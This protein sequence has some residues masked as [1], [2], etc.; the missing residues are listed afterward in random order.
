M[1]KRNQNH[2]R[3]I[4][5]LIHIRVNKLTLQ[6]VIDAKSMALLKLCLSIQRILPLWQGRKEKILCEKMY[7]L[8]FLSS[9]S[10]LLSFKE[11]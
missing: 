2:Y 8:N 9:D 4:I 3:K 7:V 11:F 10:T 6:F 1:K 5:I